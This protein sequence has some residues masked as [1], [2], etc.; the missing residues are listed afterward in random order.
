MIYP[1][2]V[3]L[4]M[5]RINQKWWPRKDRNGRT[6][7]RLPR[8]FEWVKLSPEGKKIVVW[9]EFKDLVDRPD[10]LEQVRESYRRRALKG[11][12]RFRQHPSANLARKIAEHMMRAN[13]VTQ[14]L[15]LALGQGLWT[16]LPFPRG[17][18]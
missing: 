6:V 12:T 17:G 5:E 13:L 7:Q 9:T 10:A 15:N 18:Y 4:E 16:D 14:I 1:E 3:A 8:F 11:L 2:P